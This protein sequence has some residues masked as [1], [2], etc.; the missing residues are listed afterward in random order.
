MCDES[1]KDLT[2]AL[3]ASTQ[4][5]A[6]QTDCA[7]GRLDKS[8]ALSGRDAL[9]WLLGRYW[10]PVLVLDGKNV[11][12]MDRRDSLLHWQTRLDGK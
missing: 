3:N 10:T 9:T 12:I 6:V 8:H 5:L 4:G 7:I 1:K 2:D 11:R